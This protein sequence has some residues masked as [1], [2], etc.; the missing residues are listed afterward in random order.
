MSDSSFKENVA[1]GLSSKN[2]ALDAQILL[3]RELQ[4]YDHS[5]LS[6]SMVEKYAAAFNTTISCYAQNAKE[7]YDP[8]GDK[9]GLGA[10]TLAADLCDH[11]RVKYEWKHGVGS[12]LRECC[13]QLLAHLKAQ[14]DLQ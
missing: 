2:D 12:A 14:K 3:V 6:P 1:V 13:S 8:K 4:E 11:L 5:I 9:M 10:H 7:L